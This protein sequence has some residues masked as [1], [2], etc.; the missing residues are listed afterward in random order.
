MRVLRLISL[1]SCRITVPSGYESKGTESAPVFAHALV[2]Y[3]MSCF[4]GWCHSNTSRHGRNRSG[5]TCIIVSIWYSLSQ[6]SFLLSLG[7]LRL[8]C[9]IT[10]IYTING[11]V[12][13]L[14]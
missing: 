3:N 8:L 2:H 5:A 1:W 10:V 13:M 4:A 11:S 9:Q 14:D 6:M 12:V 7:P